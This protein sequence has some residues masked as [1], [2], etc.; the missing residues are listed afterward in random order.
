MSSPGLRS[1][2]SF[3]SKAKQNKAGRCSHGHPAA[4]H[5]HR[6]TPA[7][8]DHRPVLPL[9]GKTSAP[10]ADPADAEN[11]PFAFGGGFAS[12]PLM[13]QQVVHVQG[14]M[15]ERTFM[16]GIAWAKSPRGLS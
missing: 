3:C 14:W 12:L 15:D 9:S 6:C 7:R 5:P 1:Q 10:H 13:L 16:D 11:R 2:P 4:N 8:W